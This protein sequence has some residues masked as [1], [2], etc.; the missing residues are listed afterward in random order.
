M[1]N[2]RRALQSMLAGGGAR[3]SAGREDAFGA[4]FG[5]PEPLEAAQTVVRRGLPP[6]KITDVKVFLTQVSGGSSATSRS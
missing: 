3:G 2:R 1:M 5:V 6:V 4:V